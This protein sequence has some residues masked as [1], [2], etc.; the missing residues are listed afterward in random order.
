[1]PLRAKVQ[2]AQPYLMG[3]VEITLDVLKEYG[4][5]MPIPYF[6]TAI[7][8]ACKVVEI[9]EVSRPFLIKDVLFT[10]SH[11]QAVKSNFEGA[12]RLADNTYSIMLVVVQSLKGKAEDSIDAE[13]RLYIERLSK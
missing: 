5:L 10:S 13:T 6:K 4:D 3:T 7:D 1:M 8:A 9:A 2:A 12:K 11:F